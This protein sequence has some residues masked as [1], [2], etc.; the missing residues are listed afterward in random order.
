MNR[1]PHA[2]KITPSRDSGQLEVVNS[3]MSTWRSGTSGVPQESVLGPVLFNNF[4]SDIDSGI[5]GTLSTF[6]DDT[7]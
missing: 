5:E 7:S 3:S 6:A 4:I 2:G 1:E